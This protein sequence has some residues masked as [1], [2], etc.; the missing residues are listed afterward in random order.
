MSRVEHRRV[1]EEGNNECRAICDHTLHHRDQNGKL[2][3]SW[4]E[5]VGPCGVR[6]ACRVCDRLFGYKPKE[7][8]R[9]DDELYEAYLEQQRRRACPGCGEEPFLG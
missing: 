8:G 2:N 3:G 5:T 9:T 4:I 1:V 7:A 6:V